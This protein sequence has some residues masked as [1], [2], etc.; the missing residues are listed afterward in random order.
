MKAGDFQ[1]PEFDV[2]VAL[3]RQDPEA[4]EAFRRRLLREAVES[5]P[6]A[7]RK[8]L[9][10]LLPRIEAARDGAKTP[11]DATLGAFRMMQNSLAQLHDGWEQAREA[12][13]ELQAAV[14]IARVRR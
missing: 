13:A 6:L 12:A 11:M 8:S 9:E 3:H 7:N 5:A 4:F 2:L 10:Q 14:I 1:V